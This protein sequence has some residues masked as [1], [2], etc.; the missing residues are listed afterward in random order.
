MKNYKLVL[1][2]VVSL[3]LEAYMI[4]CEV[5]WVNRNVTDSFRV[6]KDGCTN[7]KSV[8][9]NVSATCQPDGLCLCSEGLPN[10]RNPTIEASHGRYLYGSTYGCMRNSEIL[11]G[12]GK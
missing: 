5:V 2:W 9:T 3:S 10:F 12:V 4:R 1:F 11:V 8:C 6:G 7:D